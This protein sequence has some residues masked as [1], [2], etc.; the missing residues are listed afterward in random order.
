MLHIM[1]IISNNEYYVFWGANPEWREDQSYIGNIMA[2]LNL[3]HIE[4]TPN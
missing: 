3:P 4:F 1:L 2:D